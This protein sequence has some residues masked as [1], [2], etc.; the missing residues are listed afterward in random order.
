[1]ELDTILVVF[2][3]GFD[4]TATIR[5]HTDP[6]VYRSATYLAVLDI[7]LLLYRPVHQDRDHLSA[8]GAANGIFL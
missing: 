6:D 8:V 5:G 4:L 3:P 7:L 1:M 2:I